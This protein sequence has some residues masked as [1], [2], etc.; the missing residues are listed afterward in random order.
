MNA[1]TL[2]AGMLTSGVIL[3][4]GVGLGTAAQHG[5]VVSVPGTGVTGTGT[6]TSGGTTGGAG[7][8]TGTGSSAS[9]SSASGSGL[10]AADGTYTGDS[11]PTRFGDVQVQ[12]TVSGGQITDVTPLRLTDRDGRSV[13]ISNRAA[14]ILREEVLSAQSA[15]VRMVSGATYTSEGYLNSLQSALDQAGL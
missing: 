13:Q 15:N 2:F 8:G 11:V 5:A 10:S 7:T 14:P 12:V 6:A 9:G 3:G 4:V 1:R